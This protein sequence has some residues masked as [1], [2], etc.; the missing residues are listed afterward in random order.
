[1]KT[2]SEVNN[3]VGSDCLE[4]DSGWMER[5]LLLL[6]TN[7]EPAPPVPP[8]SS[9]SKKSPFGTESRKRESENWTPL[10]LGRLPDDFL[11]LDSSNPSA[12]HAKGEY[13]NCVVSFV[14]SYCCL[15]QIS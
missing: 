1:V 5:E 12:S 4:D 15:F 2:Y 13:R 11:R 9:P 3:A 8:R 7:T 14:Y 6:S 10:M